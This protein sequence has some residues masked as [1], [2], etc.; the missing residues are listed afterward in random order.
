MS[1]R[2]PI[3]AMRQRLALDAP[4]EASDA[5]GALQ[6]TWS[7]VGDVWGQITPASSTD[8]FVA[9]R[10]EEAV[11]HRILIRWRDG[12]QGEMRFRLGARTFLVHSLFDPDERKRVLIC[13]C[14][15]IKP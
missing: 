5:S 12:M 13:R 6:R 8:R 3:G 9:D 7:N 10:Q 15:E 14:E 11:T 4:V 2:A 1:K